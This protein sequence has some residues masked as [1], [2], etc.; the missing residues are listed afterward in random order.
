MS[1]DRF[2]PV[3]SRMPFLELE[4]RQRAFWHERKT[5][6]RSIDERP[7]DRIY[8]FYEGPPTANG[9]PGVHHVLSR[10]FKDLFPRYKTMR[11]YRVPRKGGWDTHGLPV[12]LEVE[13]ELG[14]KSKA[15]IEEYGIAEFNQR[16]RESVM[17]YVR[18]WEDMTDRIAFWIDMEEPYVTYDPNYIE[19]CWWIFKSLWDRGLIYEARR[20]TPHCPRCETSLSSHEV[21]QGYHENTPDPSIFVKFHAQ[22]DSLP[23]A[24]RDFDGDTYLLAWTT[25]PWTLPG[26]TALA[27]AAGETYVAVETA[28]GERIVLAEALVEATFNGVTD[29]TPSAVVTLPG[30]DLDGVAYDGLYEP[31]DWGVPLFRF[32]ENRLVEW[33]E[34]DG[35]PPVRRALAAGFVSMDEG[36]GIVHVAPAFGED[37]YELGRTAA[38]IL[39]Q[40]VD[41]KGRITGE[42]SPFAGLFVKDADPKIMDD[43]AARGL[44]LRRDTIEHTYPFCWRC[45]TPLLYYAKP[46]WYIATTQVRDT[47][48]RSNRELMH[49][50]PANV[51]D[52]RYGNWL[53][54]NVD[55]AV[56]RERYWG[57]PLPFWR[58][59]LCNNVTAV[60]SFDEL[61]RLARQDA[62]EFDLSDPHR[63]YVDAIT[64][65]CETCGG[66]MR[67]IP[68]VADGWFDSGAMP[69]A[70][71]HYPFENA[72]TFEERFPADYICEAVDQTRGWFYSLHAEATLLYAAEKIPEPI[73]YKHVI[74][75]GHI[76]DESGEKMSKSRGNVVDPW[77]VLDAHGADALRWYLYTA[78]PPGNPRRFSSK[79][80]G[81]AQRKFLLTLWNTYS[82]FVTYANIDNFDPATPQDGADPSDLD[83]W[84]RSAL[85]GLIETV[86]TALDNYDPTGAARAIDQFVDELSN[87]YV[88]R[89]RRRFWKS[90]DDRD[91]S[92]AYATLYECLGTLSRLIAPFTPYLA[93]EMYR[94]L[95]A[96]LDPNAPES[97]HLSDWPEADVSLID[98]ER[99][100][101]M[102]L[103]QRLA[104]LGR[105]ARSKAGVKVRQP[106]P[107]LL[108][109]LRSP[110]EESTIRRYEAML[111]D[112]LNVKA[113][114][115]VDASA[116][117]VGY[118]IKPNL[119]VLGPRMGKEVGVL[120]QAL[121]A[122]EPATAAV[123][124]HTVQRGEPVQVA[125][126]D[127]AADD[128]LVEMR[129]REGAATAQDAAYT[130]AVST[131]ISE[132]LRHEGIVRELVH[133]VQSA[134]RTA[135][136]NIADRISLWL[137][138]DDDAT[139]AAIAAYGDYLQ[140]ETLTTELHLKPPPEDVFQVNES[141]DG[142]DVIVGVRRS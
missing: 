3:G 110:D 33:R 80:V 119:P 69:Y 57:T 98:R 15:E 86:T 6:Q 103:V 100:E 18:Q 122:L 128:L 130:V 125:G 36:T 73:S 19:S 78:S 79:L 88:R 61:R 56:S 75:L 134:R 126:Y 44:L 82:F 50:Y 141:L 133:R 27:V 48:N 123:I 85:H 95:V 47:L 42:R 77:E 2:E 104:S 41:L 60:G 38:L 62:D 12:E 101:G 121:Q 112:E 129:E 105:A 22:R 142:I 28:P 111:L 92:A 10:A 99:N 40:P 135:D 49:W 83:G 16:C 31:S 43:L 116:D 113:I 21:S 23:E 137:F 32:A 9:T 29:E 1:D 55:W 138:S 59:E 51:R 4:Q 94:N 114:R 63:P 37:D 81:E 13:R 107:E 72:A 90:E 87:W 89:S 66:T 96:R 5:F 26:N 46:S 45:D 11:G 117:L 53:E 35:P 124:A 58:C 108:I 17:R 64:I 120:R 7:A 20:I 139:N 140:A 93:E 127:L 30:S 68:E 67:R 24:L 71:W 136:F 8:S 25:T 106:L 109:G 97:V 34:A 102:Q 70:Q 65:G 74:S 91:K 52:G 132:P 76:L 131:E 84:V 54:N 115:I 39:A 14:L 118:V